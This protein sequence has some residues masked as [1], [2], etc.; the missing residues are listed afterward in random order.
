MIQPPEQTA[1]PR[2][3]LAHCVYAR[4][5]ELDEGARTRFRAAVSGQDYSVAHLYAGE[6]VVALTHEVTAADVVGE[7][8]RAVR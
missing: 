8:A 7:F 5:E 1:P 2:L 6:G 3:T 4:E